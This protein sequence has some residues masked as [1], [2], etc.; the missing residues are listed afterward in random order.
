MK[1][2]VVDFFPVRMHFIINIKK[3]KTTNKTQFEKHSRETIT[4]D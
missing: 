3:Y 4:S 1:K 2:G